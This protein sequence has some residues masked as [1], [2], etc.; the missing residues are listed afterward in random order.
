MYEGDIIAALLARPSAQVPHA[1]WPHSSPALHTHVNVSSSLHFLGI[2]ASGSV[3]EH[4]CSMRPLHCSAAKL[5]DSHDMRSRRAACAQRGRL[6]L[7]LAVV[8]GDL[9]EAPEVVECLL[10]FYFHYLLADDRVTSVSQGRT[11]VLEH[12]TAWGLVLRSRVPLQLVRRQAQTPRD[13]QCKSAFIASLTC[14]VDHTTLCYP[15]L[16][17]VCPRALCMAGRRSARLCKVH[18]CL[19]VR[20]EA[21]PTHSL[22][23]QVL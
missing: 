14:L 22:Q 12:A 10:A 4:A 16:T 18:S 23:M 6:A 2:K 19:R 1:P 17:F 3:C 15:A 7:A 13:T 20:V 11:A 5:E 9:E 21:G 8:Q